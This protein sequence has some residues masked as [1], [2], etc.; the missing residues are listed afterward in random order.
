MSWFSDEHKKI[1]SQAWGALYEDVKSGSSVLMNNT[2]KILSTGYEKIK[3]GVT[4]L[5]KKYN[6]N[7]HTPSGNP[8]SVN[9]LN[10]HSENN[11]DDSEVDIS[12]DTDDYLVEIGKMTPDILIKL[13]KTHSNIIRIWIIEKDGTHKPVKGKIDSYPYIST[14]IHRWFVY[15]NRS[16]DNKIVKWYPTD[17]LHT[18]YRNLSNRLSPMDDIIFRYTQSGYKP[19]PYH[20]LF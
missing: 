1:Y 11:M 10:K 8:S 12:E 14:L 13:H 5:D 4:Y 15:E 3:E 19:F 17:D 9:N 7:D 2:T 16:L 18:E 20:P 6:T